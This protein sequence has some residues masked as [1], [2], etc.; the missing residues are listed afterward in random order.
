[1]H[2]GDFENIADPSII[3]SGNY[4]LYAIWDQRLSKLDSDGRNI[5]VFARVMGTPDDRNEIDIYA[6]G[7]VTVTGPFATRAWR[8]SWHRLRVYRYLQFSPDR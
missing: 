3:E 6:E 2:T 5:A 1:M 8:S 7:G 4:G